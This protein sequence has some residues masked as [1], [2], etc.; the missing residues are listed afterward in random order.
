[1]LPL[2]AV[3]EVRILNCDG[4][5]KDIEVGAEGQAA[6]LIEFTPGFYT[7]LF[8]HCL[9]TSKRDRGARE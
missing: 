7:A 5:A 9:V 2:A 8:L 6:S 4:G 1:M 3:G